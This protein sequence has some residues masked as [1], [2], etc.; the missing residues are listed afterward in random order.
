MENIY[1]VNVYHDTIA[2][3]VFLPNLHPKFRNIKRA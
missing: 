1:Y 2:V 3:P